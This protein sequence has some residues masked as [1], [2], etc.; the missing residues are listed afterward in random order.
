MTFGN[1]TFRGYC[2]CFPKAGGKLCIVKGKGG[3]TVMMATLHCLN[4]PFSECWVLCG[5][6]MAPLALQMTL[7]ASK[8]EV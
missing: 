4:V 2:F 3:E 8:R 1:L 7:T 6:E 5:V